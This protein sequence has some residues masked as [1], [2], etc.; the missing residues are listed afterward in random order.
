MHR[1]V[2]RHRLK[3]LVFS[4]GLVNNESG[5]L[6]LQINAE[7]A[8]VTQGISTGCFGGGA[9]VT[10]RGTDV[11]LEFKVSRAKDNPSLLFFPPRNACS[12]DSG[13]FTKP[14]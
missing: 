9:G 1:C 8:D 6:Q 5:S 14:N 11:S 2:S 13:L 10:F 7:N 3:F 4:E 12:K